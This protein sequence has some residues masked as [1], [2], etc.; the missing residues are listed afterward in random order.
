MQKI[1]VI[2]HKAPDTDSVC[3]AVVYAWIL[4]KVGKDAEAYMAGDPNEEAKFVLDYFKTKFP[5]IK[6]SFSDGE[7]V[8]IV[9]TNNP[10][11]VIDGLESAKLLEI[12]DHHKL[13]G[14]K[15]SSPVKVEISTVGC[16][17]T[18]IYQR[19]K[20][21]GIELTPEM[22]G[23]LLSAIL[24]DTLKFTS[25]TTTEEDQKA[26]DK[27]SEISGEDIEK[28]AKKM[29]DA[30]SDLTGM[31]T[32][33]ILLSDSKV[34]EMGDKRVRVSVLETTKPDN[35]LNLKSELISEMDSIKSSEDLDAMF[36]FVVDILN[37]NSQILASTEEEKEK[38]SRAFNIKYE[39][40]IVLPGVVSRKKQVVPNLEK[41][42][43]V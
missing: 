34:F 16:T 28:L 29:F 38:V 35:A 4:N 42:Y 27:L 43:A 15:T 31:T 40:F 7:E 17:A 21:E 32:R 30:K 33:D 10:E 25:P 22:A 37:S 39:D 23:L 36:F 14:L 19:A 26:A 24:S 6:T 9:D 11:E 2:G 12:I 8:V 1:T 18:L 3:S 13:S 41:V 20:F 5:E